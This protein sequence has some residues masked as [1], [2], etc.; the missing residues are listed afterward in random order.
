VS[1]TRPAI[2]RSLAS[3]SSSVAVAAPIWPT[4]Q[5]RPWLATG[6]SRWP[7]GAQ[8]RPPTSTPASLP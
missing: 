4:S 3:A 8:W 7:G 5:P 6:R 1:M 2:S